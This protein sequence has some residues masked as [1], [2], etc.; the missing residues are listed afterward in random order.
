LKTDYPNLR[1]RPVLGDFE[2]LAPLPDDLPQGR[3][4]GFFPGSTIGNLQPAD[5]ERFL[6]A[7]RRMLGEG[8]LFILGV[9]L[10]KE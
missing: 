7:A 2:H 10:V 5:A 4:I 6:T 1:V 3:R 8:A 9:D